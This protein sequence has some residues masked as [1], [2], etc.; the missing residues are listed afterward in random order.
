MRRFLRSTPWKLTLNADYEFCIIKL[1]GE[2]LGLLPSKEFYMVSHWELKGAA[3]EI[4]AVFNDP[5][6]LTRW[7]APV[8]MRGE[9][10]TK[11]DARKVGL[12]ARFFTKGLLPHTFQFVARIEA[13]DERSTIRIRTFGDFDGDCLIKLEQDNS[14]TRATICWTVTVHQPFIRRL[15]RLFKPIF[16]ANHRWAMRQGR[17][18]LQRELDQRQVGRPVSAACTGKPSF[19]HNLVFLQRR[20]RWTRASTDGVPEL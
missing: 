5:L 4:V 7:W 13:V 18:G 12:T 15:V 11:G 6:S 16:V 8:F 10:L 14:V 19:P 9:L 2:R 17:L 3:E 1:G 20:F